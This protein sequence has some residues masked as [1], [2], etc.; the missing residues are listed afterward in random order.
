MGL[1]IYTIKVLKINSGKELYFII[2]IKD[3]IPYA[4]IAHF[5]APRVSF[6]DLPYIYYP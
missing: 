5:K 4:H 1:H 3:A 2:F 6:F